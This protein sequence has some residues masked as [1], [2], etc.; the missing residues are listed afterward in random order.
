M[1][2]SRKCGADGLP[3]KPSAVAQPQARL[4]CFENQQFTEEDVNGYYYRTLVYQF[5]V[6]ELNAR[7]DG[8]KGLTAVFREKLPTFAIRLVKEVSVSDE[9]LHTVWLVPARFVR[10]HFMKDPRPSSGGVLSEHKK[11]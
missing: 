4:G 10:V 7:E 9:K 11:P 1:L 8:G 6:N 2:L 5:N 3:L